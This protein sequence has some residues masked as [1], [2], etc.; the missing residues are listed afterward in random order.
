MHIEIGDRDRALLRRL[1]NSI[2]I[3][4]DSTVQP[5]FQAVRYVASEPIITLLAKINVAATV[6][7][8]EVVVAVSAKDLVVARAPTEVRVRVNASIDHII[9]G[10]TLDLILALIAIYEIVTITALE[11]RVTPGPLASDGLETLMS[12]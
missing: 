12:T 8:V 11:N 3:R 1:S 7:D 6:H 10:A 2:P 4:A 9:A 5:R